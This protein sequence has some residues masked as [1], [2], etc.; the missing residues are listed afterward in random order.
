MFLDML[1]GLLNTV[2]VNFDGEC[3]AYIRQIHTKEAYLEGKN[4]R[5][6]I[7]VVFTFGGRG[8]YNWQ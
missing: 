6:T 7:Q 5:F 8:Y 2:F 3:F 4:I 1:K